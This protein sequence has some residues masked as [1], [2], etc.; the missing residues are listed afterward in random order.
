MFRCIICLRELNNATASEEH[1]FPEALGGNITI[2]NVCRECNSNLGRYVDAPLINNWL[3]EAKWML[4]C[5]PGKSGKIPN[6][7]EKGYI[8]GDPQ[9]E[10]RYEFDS[11]GKPKRLYT[12]PKVIR[13]EIDTG[14]RIRIILDKSDENRLP[15][16]LEKIAQ[17]AKNKS[18][19]MELL[20]RKEVHVEHP[21]MELNFTFNLWDWQRGLLKIVYELACMELGPEY[22]EDPTAAKFRA[23]LRPETLSREQALQQGLKGT[24]RILGGEKPLLFLVDNP[25]WMVGGLLA[26]GRSICGYVNLFNI[27]EGSIVVTVEREKYW[28]CQ[29]NGIIW[30]IDV[31]N[32][33]ASRNTLMELVRAF[34]AES[35]E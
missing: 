33:S 35:F 22:L 20:S 14:E 17:R 3:I 11:S 24:I 27:F 5:L 16:I 26:T 8:A 23:I 21:T 4:L 2:K 31:P 28:T 12:V 9:H 34:T 7:L 19:R 29:D 15:I 10:V 30:V 1:I 25:D 13:E 18:L 6:P 32:K